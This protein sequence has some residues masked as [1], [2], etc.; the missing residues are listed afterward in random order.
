[1]NANQYLL[2]SIASAVALGLYLFLR[3]GKL[4][5]R[6]KNIIRG[7]LFAAAMIYL[8]VDLYMKGRYIALLVVAA[9]SVAFGYMLFNNKEK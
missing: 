5:H 1:M 6:N 3:S 8:G 2:L 4:S 9:G 7:V